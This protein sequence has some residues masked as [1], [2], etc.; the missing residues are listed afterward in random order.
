[1]IE[2][3]EN[4]ALAAVALAAENLSK[5]SQRL[6]TLS[7]AEYH[8]TGPDPRWPASTSGWPTHPAT[9]NSRASAG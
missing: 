2:N 3:S 6:F 9:R 7:L 8:T 5:A 1:V 4:L